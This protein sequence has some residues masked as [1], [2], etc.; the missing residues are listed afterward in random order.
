MTTGS[1][2][3]SEVLHSSNADLL[4]TCIRSSCHLALSA[5]ICDTISKLPCVTK[6]IWIVAHPSTTA[7]SSE[8]VQLA[9][10]ICHCVDVSFDWFTPRDTGWP[11]DFGTQFWVSTQMSLRSHFRSAW[12]KPRLRALGLLDTC[13]IYA[14]C[15]GGDQ[16]CTMHCR[17]HTL[18]R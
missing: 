2:E 16:Q 13:H 9:Q 14:T 18:R 3:S 6:V 15:C 12:Y 5:V 4:V 1:S 10:S 11:V 7:L 8:R 17:T